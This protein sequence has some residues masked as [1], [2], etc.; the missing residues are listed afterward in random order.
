MRIDPKLAIRSPQGAVTTSA[1][2]S[3]GDPRAIVAPMT[4]PPAATSSA[5]QTLLGWLAAPFVFVAALALGLLIGGGLGLGVAAAGSWVAGHELLALGCWRAADF[6]TGASLGRLVLLVFAWA[7]FELWPWRQDPTPWTTR[8]AGVGLGAGLLAVLAWMVS[9][10]VDLFD[11]WTALE[12]AGLVFSWGAWALCVVA[13]TVAIAAAAARAAWD[14]MRSDALVGLLGVAV[15]FGVAWVVATPTAELPYLQLR[16]GKRKA[17]LLA[18]QAETWATQRTARAERF[19][20]RSEPL[21]GLPRLVRA[22]MLWG[23]ADPLLVGR[24]RRAPPPPPPPPPPGS[25]GG[26]PSGPTGYVLALSWLPG[27]CAAE[28]RGPAQSLCQPPREAF[29]VHG[30]WPQ[31]GQFDSIHCSGGRRFDLAAYRSHAVP[32][33]LAGSAGH[34]WRKHGACV[35]GSQEA[36]FKATRRLFARVSTPTVGQQGRGAEAVDPSTVRRWQ[37]STGLLSSAEVRV[38]LHCRARARRRKERRLLEARV[39]FD[40]SFAPVDCP[41]K[42]GDDCP[43]TMVVQHA[44]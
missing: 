14:L 2:S 7:G 16:E 41:K 21:Q 4:N 3:G 32:S 13:L 9:R 6:A 38:A 43:A 12:S 19:G 20:G 24:A 23:A 34:Q 33:L 31:R 8:C 5:P 1:L 42:V 30:L 26:S 29:V 40:A 22:S 39:C 27:L 18:R 37:V 28:P 35:W 10:T 44:R 36:Y 17:R 15:A 25:G 11:L